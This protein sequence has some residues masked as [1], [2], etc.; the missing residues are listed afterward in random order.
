MDQF[1]TVDLVCDE[2][3]PASPRGCR[4]TSI[5]LTRATKPLRVQW[6]SA[7][8]SIFLH[9]WPVGAAP[10][11][12]TSSVHKLQQQN[13][14]S[15]PSRTG[16]LPAAELLFALSATRKPRKQYQ[17]LLDCASATPLHPAAFSTL[18]REDVTSHSSAAGSR[19]A[20]LTLHLRVCADRRWQIRG[21]L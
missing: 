11:A 7:T 6:L 20:C 19:T 8:S 17:C 21:K 5:T 12:P 18:R 9:A 3:S 16:A 1:P 4:C 14:F 13:A 2:R 10:V 15:L